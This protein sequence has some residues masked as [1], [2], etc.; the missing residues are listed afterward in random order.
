[1]G[2]ISQAVERL[3]KLQYKAVRMITGGHHGSRQDIIENI[4]M[5]E[6]VQ[7]KIWDMKVRATARISNGEGGAKRPHQLGGGD[8]GPEL[9]GSLHIIGINQ[10]PALPNQPGGDLGL[11]RGEWEKGTD[12]GIFQGEKRIHLVHLETKDTPR[13]V[14]EMR[15]RELE[16]EEGWTTTFTDGSGLNDTASG[17]YCSNPTRLDKGKQPDR[18]GDQYLGIKATHFD[19]ELAGIA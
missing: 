4:S 18:S 11:D 2:T 8:E 16:E 14:W 15:I 10:R 1:M 13:I 7:V 12:V 3:R 19:R 9:D 6:P 17:G 5:V